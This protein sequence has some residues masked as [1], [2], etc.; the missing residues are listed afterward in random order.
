M[1]IKIKSALKSD[2]WFIFDNAQDVF[3]LR[4]PVIDGFWTHTMGEAEKNVIAFDGDNP[5]HQI[6]SFFTDRL[7]SAGW[8]ITFHKGEHGTFE[9][10]GNTDV[11]LLNDSGKTIERIF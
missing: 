9:F 8:H 3:Y 1:I 2:G 7:D 4:H 10:F 11:Y 5:H 6:G